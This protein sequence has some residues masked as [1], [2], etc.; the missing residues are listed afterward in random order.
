MPD[1]TLQI[2]PD[3]KIGALL[4]AYPQLEETLMEI[5]PAFKKLKNPIFRKTV[6]K[7]TSIRQAARV[8]GVPL[9]TMVNKLRREAGQSAIETAD[10]QADT[11]GKWSETAAEMIPAE[12]IYK[13]L[14]AR[15]I[16]EA[17]EQPLGK[18]LS[19][20]RQMPQGAIYELIT[21]FEPAP[22]IDR[23][24]SQG[25]KVIS[26]KEADG[27]YKTYFTHNNG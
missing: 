12:R 24:K 25:F 2:T 4:D 11:D 22:L 15:E 26:R 18:V 16:I 19:D 9:G 6:A 21:P 20:L 17:G 13:T 3:T 1:E 5:T 23:A 14:D 8:G 10:E 27:L 7:V